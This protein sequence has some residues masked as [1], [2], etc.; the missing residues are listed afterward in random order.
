MPEKPTDRPSIAEIADLT[1]RLR[2]L[3]RPGQTP[4]HAEVDRF[5]ADK[6]ALLD[7][8]AAADQAADI[9]SADIRAA[10]DS[11][12]GADGEPQRHVHDVVRNRAV[13]EGAAGDTDDVGADPDPWADYRVYTA[14]EAAAELVARGVPPDQAPGIVDRYI[15]GMTGDRGWSPQDQWQIDDDDLAAITAPP[16]ES[17]PSLSDPP[18]RAITSARTALAEDVAAEQERRDQLHRWD[19]AGRGDSAEANTD[20]SVAGGDA[21]VDDG[22]AA[23]RGWTDSR[24]GAPS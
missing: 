21:A 1:R 12:D 17:A 4:D 20:S 6:Q 22:S 11:D 15:D 13:A 7:R 19:D 5:L 23:G 16:V 24:N 18:D 3:S 10:D 8:I 9:R 2:E 14:A